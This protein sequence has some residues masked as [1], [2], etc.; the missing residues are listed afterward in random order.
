[1]KTSYKIISSIII[2]CAIGVAVS[3][4]MDLIYFPLLPPETLTDL[5]ITLERTGCY[6]TCPIY[7]LTISGDGNVV[8]EGTRFVKTEGIHSFQIPQENVEELVSLFYQK[9]YFSLNDRYEVPAT[10]LP[11]VITSLKVDDKKKTVENYGGSGP[12]RLHEIER[13]IDE[14]T[15]SESFWKNE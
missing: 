13:K 6:G 14:L 8:Y 1:M 12:E 5:E 7:S 9:D 3:F 15:N 2:L 11:T 10:D 4:E